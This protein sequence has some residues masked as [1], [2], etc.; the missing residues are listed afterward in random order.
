MNFD[1][2]QPVALIVGAAAGLG[3]ASA[4]E[5]ARRAEG[6]LILADADA[7]GLDAIADSFEEPPE[8]VSTLGFDTNDAERWRQAV[9]FIRTHY[10]RLDWAVINAADPAEPGADDLVQWGRPKSSLDAASLC[11]NMLTPLMR[12][13]AQGGAII[14]MLPAMD[15]D[16]RSFIDTAA[17]DGT[18]DQIRV[19][20]IAG[21]AANATYWRDAPLFQDLVRERGNARAA[22]DAMEHVPRRLARYSGPEP[23]GSLAMMLL[24]GGSSISGAV[25]VMDPGH[26]I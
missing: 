24:A 16:A 2:I 12:Y 19:N 18:A 13:N 5:I 10:G 20:A 8:R 6:G 25:L 11:L 26:A 17:Q 15:D 21:G 3:A 22:L 1:R 23:A 4:S 9:D 7:S 14:L